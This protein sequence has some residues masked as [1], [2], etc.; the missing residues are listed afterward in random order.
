MTKTMPALS[1]T[2]VASD[3]TD[4]AM[5]SREG[6]DTSC[7]LTISDV[8]GPGTMFIP[9]PRFVSQSVPAPLMGA[10]VRSP[11]VSSPWGKD[12]CHRPS[13][14]ARLTVPVT[15]AGRTPGQRYAGRRQR[16]SK[17]LPTAERSDGHGSGPWG[18]WGL[19]EGMER[20]LDGGLVD[21]SDLV[22]DVSDFVCPAALER[23]LGIDRGQRGEQALAAVC[24][25]HLEVFAFE[26]AAVKVRE[27]Q[28][29]LGRA[30]GRGQAKVEDILFAVRTE[31]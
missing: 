27:E 14:I 19:H 20:S 7:W 5:R 24:A 21:L 29:P 16:R 28:L 12:V 15:S 4:V 9:L 2:A 18:G 30:F 22:E 8:S 1:G 11:A 6:F 3:P 10:D 31:P 25:D 23:D 13:G 26:A 17:R